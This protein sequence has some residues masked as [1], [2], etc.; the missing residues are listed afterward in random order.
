MNTQTLEEINTNEL[1]E[2]AEKAELAR[3]QRLARIP[4]PLFHANDRPDELGSALLREFSW[5]KAILD[6]RIASYFEDLHVR[7][8]DFTP[9]DLSTQSYYGAMVLHYG[10]SVKERVVLAIALAA[11]LVPD[12]LDV[13]QTR[14]TLYDLPYAEFGASQNSSRSGFTPTVQ[15]ALYILAGADVTELIEARAVFE[16]D[17]KLLSNALLTIPTKDSDSQLGSVLLSVSQCCLQQV[18]LG[19]QSAPEY[20]ADFPATALRTDQHWEELVLPEATQYHLDEIALWL[21]HGNTLR[22]EWA[23]TPQVQGYKALFYGPPGTGKTLTATLL[24]KKLDVPVYRVDLSQVVS[25]YIGETEK[26]LEKVFKRAEQQNWILLFDEADALFSNRGEVNSANDRHANQEVAYLL[27]RIDTCQNMVILTSNLK[28]NIDDAF[29][30][31]FQSI[32]YFPRPQAEQRAQLWRRGFSSKAD[33]S[34]LDIDW[35]AQEY[36]LTGAEIN[37]I[38]RFASLKSIDKN[39]NTIDPQDIIIGIQ[40]EK[41][42][43]S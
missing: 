19:C 24:A 43:G 18:L 35:L 37:N 15:T 14:N 27:Q 12:L 1:S 13:L 21:R 42:K 26:N 41:Q 8:A 36:D 9:P 25:K 7:V 39:S 40:R 28:D 20:S 2:E 31:R 4:V 5:L 10:L 33:L 23:D 3:A 29:L 11:E 32:I 38:I 16:P 17:G 30:R 22:F 6:A 34:A